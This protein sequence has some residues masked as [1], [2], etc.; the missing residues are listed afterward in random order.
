MFSNSRPIIIEDT[1]VFG[2]RQKY[3][4]YLVSVYRIDMD[5]NEIKI[6]RKRRLGNTS[7][8]DFF[9]PKVCNTDGN[10]NASSSV[11]S[12]DSE[13]GKGNGSNQYTLPPVVTTPDIQTSVSVSTTPDIQTSASVSKVQHGSK[14]VPKYLPQWEGTYK[15]LSLGAN[16]MLCSLCM[17][18]LLISGNISIKDRIPFLFLKSP[19]F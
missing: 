18:S 3:C 1:D 6:N 10:N 2:S 12:E 17:K 8:S 15:W 11:I 16:G 7:I 5:A 13:Q 9:K 4:G 14:T 19:L